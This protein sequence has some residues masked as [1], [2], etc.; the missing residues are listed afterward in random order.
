MAK[1][2]A[3]RI[4]EHS[5]RQGKLDPTMKRG[6]W[7][8]VNP[9]EKKTPTKKLCST[10]FTERSV[11][12]TMYDKRLYD[13]IATITATGFTVKCVFNEIYR[14]LIDVRKFFTTDCPLT[15][16]VA[17]NLAR[18]CSTVMIAH[19]KQGMDSALDIVY[20]EAQGVVNIY[21]DGVLTSYFIAREDGF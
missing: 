11:T 4:R 18:V 21:V 8:G 6:S 7:N 9:I 16:K 15:D 5:A 1:S 20:V 10:N 14:P 13:V 17:E 19:C 2:K 12:K 3:K